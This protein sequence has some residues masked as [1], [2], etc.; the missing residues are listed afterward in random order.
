MEWIQLYDPTR[1]CKKWL[2][3]SQ[4][5]RMEKVKDAGT[6]SVEASQAM[7]AAKRSAAVAKQEA[8][9]EA[10]R[11]AAVAKRDGTEAPEV[12]ESNGSAELRP[13]K[14]TL[15]ESRKKY[16]AARDDAVA[17]GVYVLQTHGAFCVF[18]N[19]T[20]STVHSWHAELK[21]AQEAA[22]TL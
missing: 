19:N 20:G 10:K 21:D 11:A 15:D 3:K 12:P 13:M 18:R 5:A 14:K 8:K 4:W 22:R 16:K 2:P 6:R 7:R 9:Q 17:K 1:R